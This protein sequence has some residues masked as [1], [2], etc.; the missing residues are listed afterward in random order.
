MIRHCNP[1][2]REEHVETVST[3]SNDDIDEKK[4]KCSLPFKTRALHDVLEQV[5]K[6]TI[7]IHPFSSSKMKNDVYSLAPPMPTTTTKTTKKKCNKFKE[8]IKRRPSTSK[9]HC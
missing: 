1:H 2:E 9:H 5:T 3:S 8:D 6:A 7:S 4:V